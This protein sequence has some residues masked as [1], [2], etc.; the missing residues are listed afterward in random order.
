MTPRTIPENP[1]RG[2]RFMRPSQEGYR[3]GL[4]DVL[5]VLACPC[6]A[7]RCCPACRQTGDTIYPRHEGLSEADAR[8]LVFGPAAVAA[9]REWVAYFDRLQAGAEGDPLAEARRLYHGERME[10]SRAALAHFPEGPNC[11]PS[12]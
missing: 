7:G 9:L 8:L 3:T 5:Q 4:W 2:E 6:C 10:R 11:P 12:T 1:Q